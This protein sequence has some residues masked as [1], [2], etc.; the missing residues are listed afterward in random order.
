MC[1]GK[2]KMMRMVCEIFLTTEGSPPVASS[3]SMRYVIFMLV[4]LKIWYP[5]SK[6]YP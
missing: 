6:S 4:C 2:K 1:H 5:Y 3:W